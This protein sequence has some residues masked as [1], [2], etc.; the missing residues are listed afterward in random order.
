MDDFMASTCATDALMAH[1]DH[2]DGV[3]STD[4]A[5]EPMRNPSRDRFRAEMASLR[6]QIVKLEEQKRLLEHKHKIQT[7]VMSATSVLWKSIAQMQSEWRLQTERENQHLKETLD[8]QFRMFKQLEEAAL[9]KQSVDSSSFVPQA[10]ESDGIRKLYVRYIDDVQRAY[11]QM[12]AAC[13]WSNGQSSGVH[14]VD[15]PVVDESDGMQ[16]CLEVRDQKWTP[17]ELSRVFNALWRAMVNDFINSDPHGDT[18]FAEADCVVNRRLQRDGV[19]I[20]TTVMKKFVQQDHMALVWRSATTPVDGVVGLESGEF[21][22]ET[23]WVLAER[24][25]GVDPDSS[26]RVSICSRHFPNWNSDL[27]TATQPVKRTADDFA[28]LILG[29]TQDDIAIISEAVENILLDDV[30]SIN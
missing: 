17:F 25:R 12:N 27:E 3:L 20:S 28:K 26:T 13:Q 10:K 19:L 23:G 22:T 30:L 18:Y 21:S 16:K 1:S 9:H 2:D 14:W 15:R 8:T 4:Q 5:K 11:E 29:S 7:H 6:E 24:V